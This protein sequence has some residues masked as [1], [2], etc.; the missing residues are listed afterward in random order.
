M[1]VCVIRASVF[2]SKLS[3]LTIDY[4]NAYPRHAFA[5]YLEPNKSLT[6]NGGIR[7]HDDESSPLV[8]FN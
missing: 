2:A 1:H 4:V 8:A 6:S 5:V 3:S 7:L